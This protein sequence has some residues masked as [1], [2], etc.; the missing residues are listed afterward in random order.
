VTVEK[1]PITYSGIEPATFR[2][3]ASTNYATACLRVLRVVSKRK[4]NPYCL[5]IENSK[6][7]TLNFILSIFTNMIAFIF[8]LKAPK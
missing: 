1:N 4:Q 3:G 5:E 2:H 7:G 6:F 8:I